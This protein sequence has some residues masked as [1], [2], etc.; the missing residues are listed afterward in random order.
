M[1]VAPWSGGVIPQFRCSFNAL[2]GTPL[3]RLRKR[4]R[5]LPYLQCIIESRTVRAAAIIVGVHRTTSFRWRHR[6]V[7]RAARCS[8]V[9]QALDWLETPSGEQ[10]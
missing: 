1:A 7:P 6:F 5:W 4:E 2:T 10:A 8:G 9:E 3:A